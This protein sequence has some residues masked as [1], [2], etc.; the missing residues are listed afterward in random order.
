M[1][2][3][4]RRISRIS[5]GHIMRRAKSF[6]D[7]HQHIE[8]GPYLVRSKLVRGIIHSSLKLLA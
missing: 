8:R 4:N 3:L 6:L 5:V 2:R 1:L 7:T